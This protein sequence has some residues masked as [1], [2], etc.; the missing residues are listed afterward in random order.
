LQAVS[1]H[2]PSTQFPLVHCEAAVHT[3]PVPWSGLQVPVARSQYD[4]ATHCASLEQLVEQ[5]VA[6]AQV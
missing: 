2:T 3:A 6:L 4:A 5:A 1:Q